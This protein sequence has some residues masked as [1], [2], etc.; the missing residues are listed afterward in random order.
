MDDAT[1]LEALFDAS[2]RGDLDAIV[3]LVDPEFEGVV[4]SSMSV[5]PDVYRGTDGVRRYFESFWDVVDGM[6]FE[7]EETEQHGDWV[8]AR[9]HATGSGRLSG[10]PIDNHPVIACKARADLVTHMSAFPDMEAARAWLS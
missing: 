4:P 9:L 6:R 3:A 10:A 1:L 8:V 7:I 2:N 5:E